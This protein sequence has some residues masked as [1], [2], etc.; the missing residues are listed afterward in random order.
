MEDL[1]RG[2]SQG[3]QVKKTGSTNKTPTHWTVL[4]IDDF[5]KTL[6][7]RLTKTFLVASAACLCAILAVVTYSAV[8]YNS[9][10][11]ENAQL[12]KDLD[13]LRADLEIAERAREKAL[14]GLMAM[15]GGIEKT[16]TR[17]SPASDGKTKDAPSKVTEPKPAVEQSAKTKTSETPSPL[18]EE[19]AKAKASETP[20]PAAVASQPALA[21][22]D[23]T[24]PPVFPGRIE[25]KNLEI[26]REAGSHAFRF[27]FSLK[28]VDRESSSR[29]AG[30]T[31]VVLKPEEGSREP[32]RAFPWSPLKDEKP[33]I[34]KR[35]QYFSISH[36]KFVGGTLTD[37]SS[38]DRF[39]TATVYVFSDTGELLMEEVFEVNKILRGGSLKDPSLS[40]ES[41]A[42]PNDS[43]ET[44]PNNADQ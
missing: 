10:R 37:V 41:G 15:E 17:T 38:I 40:E 18:A 5:G 34:F 12:R 44:D 19:S 29:V 36:F 33:A 22:K 20:S 27:Q 43:P 32:I 31:F 25:V 42:L 16:A 9:A 6:S 26:W 2:L 7:F 14:V 28:N 4:L 23:E 35:G 21:N 3:S 13:T 1:S 30:H 39:K 8:S 11:L 24:T